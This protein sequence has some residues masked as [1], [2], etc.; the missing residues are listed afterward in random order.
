MLRLGRTSKSFSIALNLSRQNLTRNFRSNLQLSKNIHVLR[1]Q[2][3][4][5]QRYQIASIYQC[6]LYSSKKDEEVPPIEE[7]EEVEPPTD[8]IHTN[9]PTTVAIP[10]VWPYLPCIAVNRNPVF[11][12]FMKI[13]EVRKQHYNPFWI[14]LLML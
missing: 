14:F 2:N 8:F 10:E 1:T 4:I 7:V 9:L 13:L 3:L 6:R 12:R 5:T 11:P